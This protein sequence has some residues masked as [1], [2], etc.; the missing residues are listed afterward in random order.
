MTTS[1]VVPRFN[2]GV[3]Q[4]KVSATMKRTCEFYEL[5]SGGFT[6]EKF[7]E[8]CVNVLEYFGVQQRIGNLVRLGELVFRFT[9]YIL[10]TLHRWW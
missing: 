1:K 5:G 7:F 6:Y 3:Q 10:K 9:I 4:L 2:G 8:L